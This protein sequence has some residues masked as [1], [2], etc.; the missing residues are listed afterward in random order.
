MAADSKAFKH[1]RTNTNTESAPLADHFE[2]LNFSPSVIP[3]IRTGCGS[4]QEL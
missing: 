2:K 4:F 3:Y 1:I